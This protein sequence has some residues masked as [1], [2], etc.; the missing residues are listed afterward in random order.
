MNYSHFIITQFNLRNFPL[1]N[2]ND[3]DNWLRWT[4]NRILLFK[5][6]C[7]PSIIN[8][9]CKE[10]TWLI[11]FDNDTPQEFNGFLN[12]LKSFS[13][14]SICYCKGIEDFKK[15]YINEVKARTG[16]SVEWIITT[17][18]D[19]DDCIHKDAIKAIQGCFVEKHKYLISLAS[20]YVLNISDRTLSHYFYPMSPF[21][22][23]IEIADNNI[24]G[25]FEKG[26]TEWNSLRL[27]IF[28]EIWLEYFNKRGRRSRFLLKKPLWIQTFHGENVSN[29]FYRGFP[30]LRRKALTDFSISYSTNKLSIIQIKKYFNYVRWKRYLK[31]LIVKVIINK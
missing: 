6:Y 11:Y 2:N 30:I 19:N 13:F 21:I 4:R 25:V 17:R 3:F 9:S 26:H 23:L 24:K 31:G 7:L 1:S 14:I 16:G 10:F 15:N 20:G 22:S 12:E 29:S 18:I 5:E 8:Q 28:K 27:F